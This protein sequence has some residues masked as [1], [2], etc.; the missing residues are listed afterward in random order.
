MDSTIGWLKVD[1]GSTSWPQAVLWEIR[2][3]INRVRTTATENGPVIE[4]SFPNENM[5]KIRDYLTSDEF[6]GFA[7]KCEIEIAPGVSSGI[8]LKG[9]YLP[10][11]Q[12]L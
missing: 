9:E 12:A 2:D 11:P 4:F 3:L 5:V 1:S 8:V 10:W 7:D 6:K